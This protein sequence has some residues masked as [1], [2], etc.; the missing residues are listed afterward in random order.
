LIKIAAPE[1]YVF[2]NGYKDEFKDETELNLSDAFKDKSIRQ[3][4]LT[5]KVYNINKGHNEELLNNSKALNEYAVFIARVRRNEKKGLKREESVTEAVTYCINNN[6]MRDFL[7][8][9]SGEVINMLTAEFDIEKYGEA[10]RKSGEKKGIIEGEKRGEKK[11]MIKGE[12]KGEKRG[13]IEVAS[14]A[15]K[16]GMLLNDIAK[17]TGLSAEEIEK[18][19]EKTT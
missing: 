6:I 14:E 5:V 16:M 7:K 10:M 9:Y 11:G 15:L 4:E 2:Y 3:L 17:I 13:K 18:L 1:F 12:K 19:K 8:D